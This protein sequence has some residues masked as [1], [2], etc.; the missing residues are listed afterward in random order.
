MHECF[1]IREREDRKAKRKLQEM[2]ELSTEPEEGSTFQYLNKLTETDASPSEAPQQSTKPK[3]A[4]LTPVETRKRLRQLTDEVTQTKNE[5]QANLSGYS[6]NKNNP[7][8][9]VTYQKKAQ[10]IQKILEKKQQ[11][12]TGLQRSL[13]PAKKG[14][15]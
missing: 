4:K 1:C 9:A 11:E 7:D 5:L 3:L 12:I 8:L 13:T 6:R 10:M 15:F 2:S 14:I